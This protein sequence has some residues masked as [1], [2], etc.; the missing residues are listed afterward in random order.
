M[1][2]QL[3]TKTAQEI[4]RK[5]GESKSPPTHLAHRKHRGGCDSPQDIPC[6]FFGNGYCYAN[7]F[8]GA[9]IKTPKEKE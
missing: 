9:L 2:R 1:T 8:C 5:G 4:G 6:Y 3:D 7:H